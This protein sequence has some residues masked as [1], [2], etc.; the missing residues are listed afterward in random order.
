MRRH[1]LPAAVLLAVLAFILYRFTLLPGLDFGDTGSFQATVGS[2]IIT[3]RDGYPLY[4]AI[5]AIILRLPGAGRAHAPNL[6][7]AAEGA[8]ACGVLLITAFELS[9]SPP[10]ATAA[11]LLFTVSYTF[12]SQ[13]TIAE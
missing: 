1:V 2:P 5:G 13:A 4:F 11:A 3:P 8:I 12:W 10:A 6:P 7:S 9:G